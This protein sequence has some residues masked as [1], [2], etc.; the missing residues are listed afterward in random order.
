MILVRIRYFGNLS[1]FVREIGGGISERVGSTSFASIG[2]VG[3]GRCYGFT[4][5]SLEFFFDDEVSFVVGEGG[6]VSESIGQ[7]LFAPEGIVG[8]GGSASFGIR[9][10]SWFSIT[11]VVGSDRDRDIAGSCGL[12]EWLSETVE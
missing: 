3:I 2:V 10:L 7:S 1:E 8:E 9:Y 4:I 11:I 12:P 5:R 6:F